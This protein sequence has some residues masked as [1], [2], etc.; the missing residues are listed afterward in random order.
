MVGKGKVEHLQLNNKV[1]LNQDN[2]KDIKIWI[3]TSNSAKK[4]GGWMNR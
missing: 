2:D 4:S 1:N 3:K